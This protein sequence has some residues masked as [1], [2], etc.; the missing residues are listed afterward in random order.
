VAERK[1][2]IP[3]AYREG[4]IRIEGTAP[5]LMH[6]DT[7][8]DL[9]HP[10]TREF[11]L[12]AGK[13]SK[14]RTPDDEMN[15]AKLEWLA[16]IYH[17]EDL[18]PFIPGVNVKTALAEAATRWKKGATIRRSL[19]VLEHKLALEFSGPRDLE[20]LWEEGYRDVRGAVNSG[21]GRGRVSRCRPCFPDWALTA[22][23]AYDPAEVGEDTVVAALEVAQM[24]GL[25]DFRPEFGTFVATWTP[26]TN[27][28]K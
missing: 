3:A 10:I 20:T 14:D 24:R 11:K 21:Y 13:S 22:E 12:L 17:D 1:R 16:G 26:K 23:A 28:T 7:L 6:R 4:T 15:L 27:G 19:I 8:L 18:G 5:L 25:G 9:A 2:V